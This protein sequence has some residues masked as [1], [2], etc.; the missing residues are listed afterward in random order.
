[1]STALVIIVAYA[2]NRVIG[3]DNALPWKLPGDLAHFKRTTL[4][5]PIIMGRKTWESLGRPLPGRTNIVISRDPRYLAQGAQVVNTIDDAIAACAD[6]ATAY[7]IGGAQLYT[8]AL[9]RATRI[10]ATEVHAE[11]SGDAYFPLLPS[12][13]WRETARSEQAPENGLT[14]AFVEYERKSDLRYV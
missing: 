8:Q 2:S 1:M 9:D 14:Y 4:G 13:A 12:F 3:R 11:I 7:V 5:S 10:V 6:S